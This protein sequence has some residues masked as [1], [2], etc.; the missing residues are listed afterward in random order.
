MKIL[1]I[2]EYSGFYNNLADGLKALG[3]EVFLANTGDGSR[4]F[5]SD[6]NWMKGKRNSIG[7]I[8]G[9]LDLI[10][11]KNLFKGY[12]VVQVIVPK[13]NSFLFLNKL[14]VKFL[15]NNNEKVFWTPAG[16]GDLIAKYWAESKDLK[17]DIYE[18]HFNEARKNNIKLNFKKN[19]F[20]EYENWFINS[21]SGVIPV[22][23]EY[24][25]PFRKHPKYLGTIPFPIN[26]DKIEYKENTVKERIIFYHGITRP[27]KG[28]E[29][30]CEAFK[31]MQKKYSEIAEFICNERL[32]YDQYI[33]IISNVNVIV[34]QTN[35]FS[36][37]LNG[38]MSLAQGKIVLGGAEPESINELRYETCPIINIKPNVSQI[39]QSIEYVIE[40][41]DRINKM[42]LESRMFIESNHDYKKVAAQYLI[43]WEQGISVK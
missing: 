14:F 4:K 5:S 6:Y 11:H 19:Q 41:R 36:T 33:K 24:A 27:V 23:F 15:I 28:T 26:T 12:D 9:I 43:T 20:I 30:I 42:G 2:G 32:P 10:K 1:L 37:A 22:A 34:D 35:S 29:Y 25:E 8:L 16:S 18:F 21:I 7:K 3:H 38:L 31:I 17:C 13:L 39:C 40:N